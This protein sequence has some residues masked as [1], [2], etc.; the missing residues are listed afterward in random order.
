M[1]TEKSLRLG[2]ENPCQN[3]HGK[4][5]RAKNLR[6]TVCS[7]FIVIFSLFLL[8]VLIQSQKKISPR[9]VRQQKMTA[10]GKLRLQIKLN[11]R[12]IKIKLHSCNIYVV[13]FFV[14]NN[15]EEVQ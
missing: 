11:I 14:V 9:R 7:F 8:V 2:Q 5:W 12:R 10:C 1:K 13:Y 6:N 4:W 3:G 15:D